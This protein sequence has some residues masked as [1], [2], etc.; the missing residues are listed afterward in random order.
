MPIGL[1]A[2]LLTIPIT[3][4]IG[5][6]PFLIW[7]IIKQ[8]HVKLIAFMYVGVTITSV[9]AIGLFSLAEGAR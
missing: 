3:L 2:L 9:L 4:G 1:E 7:A 5:F 6:A 8:Q